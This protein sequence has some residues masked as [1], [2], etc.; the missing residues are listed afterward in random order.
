MQ[1][2]LKDSGDIYEGQRMK[3]LVVGDS[4]AGKT[5]LYGSLV[6]AGY[7]VGI[8]HVDGNADILKDPMIVK[9][10][11]A[12]NLSIQAF[13]TE[14]PS[15]WDK[16]YST[17]KNWPQWGAVEKWDENYILGVDSLSLASRVALGKVLQATK[18]K[19]I[20]GFMGASSLS[21]DDLKEVYGGV[22]QIFFNLVS[23]CVSPKLKCHFIGTAH[24][25][26]VVKG[27]QVVSRKLAFEGSALSADVP[28]KFG[29]IWELKLKLDG[30]RVLLTH[31]DA[32]VG[33]KCSA[34]SLI[35]KEEEADL[36]IL[37]NRLK[38]NLNA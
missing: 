19:A 21:T 16:I 4:G 3:L 38:G 14:D 15:S 11:C 12:S 7:K 9:P 18:Q 10:E 5:A 31:P 23:T 32:L 1:E 26:D 30:R 33:R 29:D 37:F 8:I 22:K 17:L 25:R 34:P 20:S 27:G 35:K 36:S 13:D 24:L 6:N 28:K 2:S